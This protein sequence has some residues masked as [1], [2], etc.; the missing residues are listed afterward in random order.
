M[1]K[2]IL[3][4]NVSTIA[5]PQI[6]DCMNEKMKNIYRYYRQPKRK[7]KCVIDLHLKEDPHEWVGQ[8]K[9]RHMGEKRRGI[10]FETVTGVGGGLS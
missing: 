7:E 8:A 5:P 1:K 3:L 2:N 6:V 9:K 10:G 4:E